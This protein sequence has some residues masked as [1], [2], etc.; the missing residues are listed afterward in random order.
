[1]KKGKKIKPFD[2]SDARMGTKPSWAVVVAANMW[3]LPIT[4]CKPS[5]SSDF[6]RPSQPE[7][8]N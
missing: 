8:V 3:M 2:T 5:T 1:M 4:C 7:E 6:A